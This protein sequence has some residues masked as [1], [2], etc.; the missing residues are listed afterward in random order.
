MDIQSEKCKPT[1]SED[2]KKFALGLFLSNIQCQKTVEQVR[3]QG[4]CVPIILYPA[5]FSSF[6]LKTKTSDKYF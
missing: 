6:P 5:K 1:L 3:K 2:F 4:Y